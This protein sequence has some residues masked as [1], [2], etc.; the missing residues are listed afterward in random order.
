MGLAKRII[1][2]LDVAEVAGFP[3]VASGGIA[4]LDD[5]AALA[6]LGPDVVEGAIVGRALYE[7]GFKLKHA[8]RA[9]RGEW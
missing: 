2:C 6:A 4:T 1:P 8:I 9:G 7:S 3:V 5:I